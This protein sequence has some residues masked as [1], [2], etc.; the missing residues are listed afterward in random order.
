MSVERGADAV[1]DDP[2]GFS[3]LLWETWSPQDWFSE[4]EFSE[5]AHS[6]EN[7]DWLAI[8]LDS[9]SGRWREEPSDP[10]YD[11]LRRRV[12]SVESLSTPTLM[13][14]GLA[15][16]TVLP[17]STEGKERFFTNG[18]K[19]VVL[20]GVGHF[21]MRESPDATAAAIIEH[22]SAERHATN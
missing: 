9:Y 17:E 8:T 16:G 4:N 22:L 20:P 3:R 10:R 21:P 14:Q 7:P 15:D 13:I 2:I 19:R 1:K 11:P 18:Y 5:T 6:F 12:R